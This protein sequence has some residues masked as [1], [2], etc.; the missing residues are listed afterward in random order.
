MLIRSK[1]HQAWTAFE[2]N[3]SAAADQD[4]IIYAD[5]KDAFLVTNNKDCVA[6]ARRMRCTRVVY[7]AVTEQ[8]A[9]E[10]MNRALEWLVAEALPEGRILRVPL[11]APL[12][13]MNPLDDP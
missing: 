11:R 4:L 10:A 9:P 3:L 12:R 7:L 6:L 5:D 1:H 8:N 2:A 13:V